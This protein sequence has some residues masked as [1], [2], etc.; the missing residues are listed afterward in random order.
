MAILCLDH[1][2]FES[3]LMRASFG[4]TKYCK[5]FLKKQSCP[6]KECP[7]QHEQCKQQDVIPPD[8]QQKILF[9]HC[10]QLAIQHSQITDMPEA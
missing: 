3:R 7:Y 4:R 5:F 6:N 9:S 10:Q 8:M 2:T 1:V